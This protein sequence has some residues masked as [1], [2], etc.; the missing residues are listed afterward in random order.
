MNDSN[1]KG[2]VLPAIMFVLVVMS[3]VSIGVV[4]TA[5][6]DR[7]A[8]HGARESGRA[9]YAAEAGLNAVVGEWDD[10]LASLLAPGDSV[11]K[12]V[13]LIEGSSYRAVIQ[14]WDNGAG[15]QPMYSVRVDGRGP[16]AQGVRTLR[17]LMTIQPPNVPRFGAC[18]DAPVT[19]RGRT[20]I[21]H[22]SWVQGHDASP[23]SWVSNGECDAD[24]EDRPG[25]ITQ[26]VNDVRVAGQA[27]I[28]GVPDL[29]V[30]PEM[31]DSTF[32][33]YG[34]LTWQ[35]V[36]DLATIVIDASGAE[37]K[38]DVVPSLN[39]NGTCKTSDPY[40]WGSNDPSHP[41]Y[42]H[43]PIVLIRGEVEVK[44]G[45]GQAVII[46]D[47]DQNN[48][49]AEFELEGT[50]VL[51]NGLI[52]GKGCVEIED[53]SKFFGAVFVDGKYYNQP[54]CAEDEPF[55]MQDDASVQWSSCVVRRVLLATGL[56]QAAG[57]VIGGTAVRL[58]S[59][60]FAQILR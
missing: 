37:Q 51:F 52:I 33:Q 16:D 21:E 41:C 22:D 40:N 36:K 9:F 6:D 28:D 32:D 31:A 26:D 34:E 54:L 29:E 59:R 47:V 18:C 42:D 35:Q 39:P 2:F 11:V 15:S 23:P 57:E 56:S 25:I 44:S 5:G 13:D 17:V 24:L 49:G 14:R 46:L 7:E 55:V 38:I 50:P 60:S 58:P 45:Y 48:I 8:S 27:W 10:S 43:F 30:Q 12:T 53:L 4:M 3:A 20:D 19:V 1:C